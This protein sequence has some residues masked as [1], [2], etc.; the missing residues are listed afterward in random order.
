[1]RSNKSKSKQQHSSETASHTSL[2]VGDT[3]DVRSASNTSGTHTKSGTI[4]KSTAHSQS[5][6]IGGASSIRSTAASKSHKKTNRTPKAE[7]GTKKKTVASSVR[8][9]SKSSPMSTKTD[10]KTKSS[11]KSAKTT[12]K[13]QTQQSKHPRIPIKDRTETCAVQFVPKFNSSSTKNQVPIYHLIRHAF[14][15]MVREAICQLDKEKSGV[16]SQ[17]IIDHI[18]KH[19]SFPNNISQSAIR[20]RTIF[21]INA[22]LRAGTL[23]TVSPNKGVRIGR[24]RRIYPRMLC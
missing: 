17:Q 19:Y 18:L 21:T 5:R 1:M 14:G 23:L 7:S 6:P 10:S 12:G 4:S 15:N 11:T 22:G 8:S 9:A 20:N 3:S 24:M 16:S 2:K 13:H